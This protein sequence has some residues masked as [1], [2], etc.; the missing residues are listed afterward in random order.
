MIFG[1]S[2]ESP[3]G[4]QFRYWQTHISMRPNNGRELQTLRHI[5]PGV[6]G[7]IIAG[8]ALHAYTLFQ[9]TSGHGCGSEAAT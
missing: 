9:V 7:F 2:T 3:D 4:V 5:F 8:R 1:V 6:G